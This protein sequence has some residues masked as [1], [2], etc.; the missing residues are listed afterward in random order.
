MTSKIYTGADE[1]SGWSEEMEVYEVAV[2]PDR[3]FN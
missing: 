2:V 1:R 3:E